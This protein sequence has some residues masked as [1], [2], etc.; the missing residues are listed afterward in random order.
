MASWGSLEVEELKKFYKQNNVPS[1]QLVKDKSAI[2]Q[3]VATF[4]AKIGSDDSFS[5]K[6]VADRLFRLRKAGKLPR[7]RD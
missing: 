5:A 2:E 6:E 4:N 1:D 7:I 3:F